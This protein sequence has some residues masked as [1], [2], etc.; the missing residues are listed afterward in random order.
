MFRSF[1]LL[2]FVLLSFLGYAQ[3]NV[4][5]IRFVPEVM[6]EDL[7]AGRSYL[8]DSKSDSVR[9]DVLKY[10]V[11]NVKLMRDDSVVFDA[12]G[13]FVLVDIRDTSSMLVTLEV[14]PTIFFN[15]IKFDIGIDSATNLKGA[16]GG[17][18]DPTKGMYWAWHSG[19]I[20][21]KLEGSSSECKSRKNKF[22][23]HLGGYASP[24]STL[25]TMELALPVQNES[26]IEIGFSC[27]DFLAELDF[28]N[29]TEVMRPCAMAVELSNK[30]KR[31]F[32]LKR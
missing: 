27:D 5:S 9:I 22:Q 11:S 29:T 19:Y 18:L 3:K 13:R 23:Y 10:Y 7:V 14:E 15:K 16:L 20:N 17:A 8:V 4:V 26:N 1:V 32:Y 21:F 31:C 2:G 28:G 12:V 6:G 25:Q 30:L 24:F